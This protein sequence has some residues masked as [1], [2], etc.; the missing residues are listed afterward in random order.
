MLIL[1]RG[2]TVLPEAPPHGRQEREGRDV[3]GLVER[4]VV[5]RERPGKRHLA[6]RDDEVHQPEHHEHVEQLQIYRVA[7]G[8]TVS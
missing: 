6:E 1:R 7:E 5:G 4:P 2:V 8:K 3:L